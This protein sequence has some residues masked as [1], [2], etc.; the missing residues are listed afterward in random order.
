LMPGDESP[1]FAPCVQPLLLALLPQVIVLHY[2][3]LT[4]V[5]DPDPEDPYVFGPPGSGFISQRYG[6]GSFDHLVKIV[7]SKNNLQKVKSK[8]KLE[9]K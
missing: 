6:S 7:T 4:S 3:V 1:P 5:A 2:N 8:K 9:K